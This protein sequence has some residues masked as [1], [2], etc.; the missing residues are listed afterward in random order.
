MYEAKQAVIRL[1]K[2]T[3]D[4][5]RLVKQLRKNKPETEDL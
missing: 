5:D 3:I 1:L 2:I 4:R